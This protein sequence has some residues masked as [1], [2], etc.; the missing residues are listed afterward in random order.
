ME[1]DLRR[2]EPRR[3]G[4]VGPATCRGL[5]PLRGDVQCHGKGRGGEHGRMGRETGTCSG[6]DANAGTDTHG[7]TL[8]APESAGG[9]P[10]TSGDGHPDSGDNDAGRDRNP[11]AD[12][13]QSPDRDPDAQAHQDRK[14]DGNGNGDLE[15]DADSD[16]EA[17]YP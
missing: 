11:E 13:N 17:E 7:G 2:H 12:D 10:E 14:T 1:Q 4:G 6:A 16:R 9:T 3:P 5:A 15:P 8:K